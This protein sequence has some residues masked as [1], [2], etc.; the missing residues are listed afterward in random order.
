MNLLKEATV[1]HCVAS[2]DRLLQV[3]ITFG[4]KMI[5][6]MIEFLTGAYKK[7]GLS[8]ERVL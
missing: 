2:L 3:E 8:E 4:K 7:I 6:G 5:V 1:E